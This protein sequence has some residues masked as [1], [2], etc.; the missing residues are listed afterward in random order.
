[1]DNNPGG[2]LQIYSVE[3]T[4][5]ATATCIVRCVGGVV[6]T[7]QQ[8]KT[9]PTADTT[10]DPVLLSLNWIKRYEKAMNFLDPPHSGVIQLSG[11]GLNSLKRGVILVSVTMGEP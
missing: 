4:D 2:E 6:R 11:N 1:M 9:R 3:A 8:F 5:A 7:G 10:G